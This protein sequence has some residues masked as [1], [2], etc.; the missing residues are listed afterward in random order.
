MRRPLHCTPSNRQRRLL[1]P[2]SALTVAAA[3]LA[4]GATLT[5]AAAAEPAWPFR[6]I[7]GWGNNV[8]KPWIGTR[9]IQLE[10]W[11]QNNYADSAAAPAGPTRPNPRSISNAVFA[12]RES[13]PNTRGAS[14]FL[15]QWGQFLDHDLSLSEARAPGEAMPIVVP[16]QDPFFPNGTVFAFRRS[17]HDPR[18]GNG[19]NRPRQQL[20]ALTAWIDAS[21]VYGSDYARAQA[22]RRNDG[23]GELATSRGDLLP[24]NTAGLPNAGGPQPH[25][26][27]AG[28]VRANEQLGLLA[29][30]T[31]F[32]REHNR[33]AR[34]Y[35][36]RYPR[37]TDEQIYQK[38]RQIVGAQMQV[39]TYKEFL[40]AL[41][42]PYAPTVYQR[43]DASIE[44]NVANEFS[45]AA[46]R[47]GHSAVGPALLRL[48]AGLQPIPQ[49]PIRLRDAFFQP[50]RLAREGGIEPLLRGL[51]N[52]RAQQIDARV[53]DDIRNFLFGRPTRG[54]LD[55]VSLNIQRG[56][57][58]GLPS[59]ATARQQMGQ[60]SPTSFADITPDRDV[61]ARLARVY[62]SVHDVDLW[63]GG[64]AEPAVSGSHLGRLFSAM[65]R[66]QFTLLRDGDRFWYRRTLRVTEIAEVERTR[67]S[68]IIKRNTDIGREMQVNVFR[69]PPGR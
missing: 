44:G 10:R 68:D 29:V 25:F 7:D 43:Y 32:V 51:A 8:A 42:G 26:F 53:V 56:R 59:Y 36:Q 46:F 9:D 17:S 24:L 49:G 22:L 4:A 47:F 57:D 5:P 14:D 40:P 33:L 55:L 2:L 1:R 6:A 11:F 60:G 19:R 38:A 41:L 58:H 67:L 34:L 31:L 54:G 18:T 66:R 20:N 62:G 61:Q 50:R 3:V 30:H 37:W 21:Q 63:V 64:L 28:D 16:P 27:L 23:S 65:L 35:K 15:W 12:Q 39:V 52:Q 69:V 48:D 45:T 13:V